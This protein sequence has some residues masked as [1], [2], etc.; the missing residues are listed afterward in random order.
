MEKKRAP[1][2]G[3]NYWR[4]VVTEI[5]GSEDIKHA[6]AE[7]EI[8]IHR[9][10]Y[11]RRKFQK[12]ETQVSKTFFRELD[13]GDLTTNEVEVQFGE[14]TSRVLI[15]GSLTTERLTTILSSVKEV[16]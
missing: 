6:C 4:Q 3:A 2:R 15:R 16:G 9:Y 8:P 5:D 7:R 13:I 11:W 14:T 10:Y 1:R 12:K